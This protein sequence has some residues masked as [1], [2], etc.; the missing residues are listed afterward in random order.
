MTSILPHVTAS[1][2]ALTL[3]LLVAGFVFIRRRRPKAHRVAMM[4]ALATST[5]FL[6]VYL[7]YH[8]TQ[9]IYP[10]Q[11]Q[12]AARPL[13]YVIL[14]THV[15]LAAAVLPMVLVAAARALRGN[16]VRHRRLARWTLPVWVY[17]SITGIIVYVMLYRID[18]A[19]AQAVAAS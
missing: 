14:V 18:W 16:I 11:G 7:T 4:A 5:V 6:G 19:A 2:N 17:V 12:G 10:F 1:L 13:Y 15:V 9:P 8:F 3:C